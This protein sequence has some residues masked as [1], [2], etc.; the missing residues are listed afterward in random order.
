[1]SAT[2]FPEGVAP[3]AL[4]RH[5]MSATALLA[6]VA[7]KALGRHS[8]RA[9]TELAPG[10]PAARGR[11]RRADVVAPDAG[12]HVAG[13]GVLL[14]VSA[15]LVGL[16][17]YAC[18]LLMAHL[19]PAAEY[20]QYAAAQMIV[21]IV[22]IVAHA[23]VPLPLADLVRRH[24]RRSA[25]RRDAMAFAWL[26]SA[27]TG[28]VAGV[29]S[30]A[31]VATFADPG[32]AVATAVASFVLF[33]VAPAQGW[34][35]GEL[36]FARYAV[37]SVLEVAARV[38]FSVLAVLAG[39]GP[40]GALIGFAVG[41]LVLVSGPVAMLRDIS[42]R[43]GVLRE[44]TRWA[45]TGDIALV[46]FVVSVLVGADVVLVALLGTGSVADAGFQALATL[47]KGPVYVAA[48]TVLVV[49]P[50]LRGG[51]AADAILRAS[52]GSFRVLALVAAV[53]LATVP[54]PL[55]LLVLPADY[56]A[57][58]ALAPW[59]AAAGLGYGAVTVLATVL[60][61]VRRYARTRAALAVAVV[62]LPAGLLAGWALGGVAGLAV[63]AAAGALAATAGMALIAAPVLPAGTGRATAR[64]VALAAVLLA[65]A[66]L[67]RGVPVL[68]LAVAA[69]AGLYV[70][71]AGRAAEPGDAPAPDGGR[72]RILHLG[73]EDP[74]MPGAGGGSRRTHEINR[75]LAARGHDVTVLTTRFPGH[76]DRVQDGVRYVHIGFGTGRT[77]LTRTA[78]Y[79]LA[80][81]RECRRRP[82]D[83]VVEDFFAP[84]SSAA[85][86]LWSGRPTVGV[87]QWLNAREKARQYRLP[88]HLVERFGVRKHDRMVAVSHH[89][90]ATLQGL[91]PSATID[92]IGNGVSPAAARERRAPG[93][94]VL[95]V[96]R[97]EIAQKGLDLLVQAWAL[98]APRIGGDLVVAGAGPDEPRLR[99]LVE[100]AGLA[101]RV[102]Y[103]GWV[104]EAGALALMAA[105]RLVAMPSRF[106]TFGMVAVEAMA[107][108]TPVVAF[109]IDALREVLP[110]GCTRRVPA[111]DVV[112]YADALVEAYADTEWIAAAAPTARRFAAGYDWDV[113]ATRQEA[114]YAAA[115]RTGTAR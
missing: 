114:V 32:V 15:G 112:A 49:F 111:F 38:G 71:R 9:A 27:G 54:A 93:P 78:G 86:P 47:A 108:G 62:A 89:V 55:V 3:K 24:A 4:G 70:L 39:A 33:A 8:M 37:V 80:A 41:G 14:S 81:V 16:L 43:P 17:S 110:A 99:E 90:G 31:V 84:V 76:R 107:T 98:A 13:N 66:W 20:T 88:F 7:P 61:A 91:N 58:L 1:M 92:V 100:R 65:V 113:L 34:L 94:D 64:D 11:H 25:G 50:M 102:R 26:V 52:L 23:L 105:A 29:A 95:F 68:W 73:F 12:V 6:G 87:V 67:T 35:Q 109:D 53:L 104:D 60:L 72:L 79:A 77:R 85:A 74:A 75:R 10:P 63:G 2:A 103:A 69:L 101:D 19:L 115:A 57:S 5:S 51:G 44:R 40:T 96:G 46:Q 83:V 28:L 18:T 56:A 30:G 45:E 36:R 48:G 97:L 59:L 42:V 106:E 21:G 82:A 22:G